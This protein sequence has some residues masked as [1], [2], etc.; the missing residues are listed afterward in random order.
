MSYITLLHNN[1]NV[2]AANRTHKMVCVLSLAWSRASSRQSR[3]R[4]QHRG[5]AQHRDGMQVPPLLLRRR[6]LRGKRPDCNASRRAAAACLQPMG[7][8]G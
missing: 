8:T 3:G 4:V 7:C 2:L 1:L 6:P 5:H